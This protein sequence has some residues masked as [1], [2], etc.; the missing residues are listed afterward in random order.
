MAKTSLLSQ[1]EKASK[2]MAKRLQSAS[3]GNKR[4][5]PGRQPGPMKIPT[6]SG[7]TAAPVNEE[8]ASGPEVPVAGH[9]RLPEKVVEE[10]KTPVRT[11]APAKAKKIEIIEPKM[12]TK[13]TR[14]RIIKNQHLVDPQPIS[15]PVKAPARQ[16]EFFL[17]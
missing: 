8:A 9:S 2:A 13:T 4:A 17:P 6:V 3:T 10:K 11:R 15:R 1:V 12:T 16:C 5:P 14:A 7:R